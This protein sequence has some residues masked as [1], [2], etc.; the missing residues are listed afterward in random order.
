VYSALIVNFVV[1]LYVVYC[2]PL[3]DKSNEYESL[4]SWVVLFP[5]PS[6]VFT[7][8]S[9]YQISV[10]PSNVPPNSLAIASFIVTLDVDGIAVNFSLRVPL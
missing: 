9:L 10:L 1:K 5:S 8:I 4:I 6:N 2:I 7:S 3:N